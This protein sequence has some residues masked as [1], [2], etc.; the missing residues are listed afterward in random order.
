MG[1]VIWVAIFVKLILDIFVYVDDTYG[2]ELKCNMTYYPPYKKFIPMKQAQLL[3]LWDFLGIRHKEK[4]QLHGASLPI[5]G[6]ELDPNAMT[7]KLPPE[8][9]ADLEK[10]VREFIDTPS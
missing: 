10:W 1:L 5:I 3:F 6:F 4:K 9:K 7:V 8:S 2:W